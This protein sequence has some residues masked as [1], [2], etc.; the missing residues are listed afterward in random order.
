MVQH[1]ESE[2]MSAKLRGS[3][4]EEVGCELSLGSTE[5]DVVDYVKD[6]SFWKAKR[7]YGRRPPAEDLDEIGRAHV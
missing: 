4:M 2:M 1:A 3:E 7:Y 6:E 5:A